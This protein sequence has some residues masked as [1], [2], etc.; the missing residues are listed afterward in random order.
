[1]ISFTRL[2]MV[3][4]VIGMMVAGCGSDSAAP[5]VTLTPTTPVVK[6]PE[7]QSQQAMN[8]AYLYLQGM[9][10]STVTPSDRATHLAL[11]LAK[12][13]DA[14]NFF[15]NQGSLLLRAFIEI[16]ANHLDDASLTLTN[17][18]TLY[19]NSPQD[20]FL[21]AYMSAQQNSD[22]S[23]V[24][25]NLQHSLKNNFSALP[26]GLWWGLVE[27]MPAFANFRTTPQYQTLLE[28]KA[29]AKVTAKVTA[30]PG[31]LNKN[32]PGCIEN[33]ALKDSVAHWYGM[34]IDLN[35][36]EV[37]TLDVILGSVLLP[38]VWITIIGPAVLLVFD[39]YVAL[40][41]AAILAVDEAYGEC[42]VKLYDTW[43]TLPIFIPLPQY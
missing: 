11:A 27:K 6:T 16:S 43:L 28:M 32:G 21:R 38:S 13:I 29:P 20:E 33:L 8:D 30:S 23:V 31:S 18:D 26:S 24:S 10:A 39:A 36:T 42:G 22:A 2:V 35:H 5:P 9:S 14:N 25:M 3:L 12:T 37:L 19:A 7:A 1:M 34:E 4:S 41:F 15:P 40:E 17:I